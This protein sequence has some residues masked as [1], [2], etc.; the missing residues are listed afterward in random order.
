ML[1]WPTKAHKLENR[2]RKRAINH[3]YR[4][5]EIGGRNFRSDGSDDSDEELQEDIY[6]SLDGGES[7]LD[8]NNSDHRKH[9]SDINV[10]ANNDKLLSP[11]ET[12]SS[13][14]KAF[15]SFGR[16]KVR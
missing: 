2:T 9:S 4:G 7:Y 13:R 12:S 3:L 11:S 8:R 16:K 1:Y 5:S 10:T 6:S 15:M 14:I